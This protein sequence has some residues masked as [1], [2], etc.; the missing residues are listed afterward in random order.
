MR[1]SIVRIVFLIVCGSHSLFSQTD[2]ATEQWINEL[3]HTIARKSYYIDQKWHRIDSLNTLMRKDYKQDLNFRYHT[4]VKLFEEYKSFIYD[5]AFACANELLNTAYLLNDKSKIGESKVKVAFTLLS[6]GLFKEAIDT[7]N[8][9]NPDQLSRETRYDYCNVRARTYFELSD[10]SN[11]T[12]YSP[13]YNKMG[14][15][16]L[17]EAQK[18]CDPQSADYLFIKG[19]RY[20]RDRN[21][22]GAINT[23]QQLLNDY[24][25]TEHEYAIS[26]SSL[27][28]MY[29][30]NNQEDKAKEYL[31]K[32]A[33]ADIRSAVC[34]TVA[35]REL[36]ELLRRDGD[37]E[38]AHRYVKI[39]LEDAYFYGAKYRKIQIANILPLIEATHLD[40]V[41]GQRQR[42]LVY[43]IVVTLLS[44]LVVGFSVITF[45]QFRKLNMTGK[46][47]A[48][49]HN[50]LLESNNKL[51]EA[52][53]I[54][55]EYIGHFYTTI[56]E[57]LDKL[58]K[59]KMSVDRKI[60]Q[61][62][63]EEIRDVVNGI[64]M[65][66]EREQLYEN[67][68]TVFLKIFPRFIE[69]FNALFK[70]DDQFVFEKNEPLPP[71]LRI[72]ALI[73]LGITENEKIA[74]I[75]RYSV[76]TIYTYK[77]RVKNKSVVPNEQFEEKLLQIK[78]L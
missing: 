28:F 2:S 29:R 43:A 49:S 37:I 31:A 57:Y 78:A 62:K 44:V 17:D 48:E 67:F 35:T 52:N 14:L 39:A 11:D 7:L 54:K 42:L 13:I 9:I 60:T 51:Q 66:R 68:D 38:R 23:F 56:S 33:I 73:R 12:H 22:V 8:S 40:M 15:P 20:M 32:A 63:F 59:L 30:L 71:E 70:K 76:N 21:I 3:D 65:K 47:L 50:N 77:T 24:P 75:L 55:E 74:M 18:L 64:N 25:L 41:E 58:D 26:T 4:Y 10:Y 5:S 16:Y 19:W 27:S 69:E 34:E 72:F 36:A 53:K 45:R 1:A 61:K 6:A 46:Q